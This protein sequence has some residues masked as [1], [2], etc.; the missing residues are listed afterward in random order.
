MNEMTPA[1]RTRFDDYLQRLRLELRGTGPEVAAEVEQSVREHIE[2]AL[3]EAQ[4]PVSE[5]DII[6]ILDRLGRPEQWVG[7]EERP[8]PRAAPDGAHARTDD[9][10]LPYVAFGLVLVAVA[11]FI[12]FGFMLL[13]PAM[14]VSR[15]WIEQKRERGEPLGARRWLVYPAIALVLAFATALL[16]FFVPLTAAS[17]LLDTETR[18]FFDIPTHPAGELRF[19]AGMRS[20]VFGSWWLIAAALCA[21]FVR[22]IRFVFSPLLDGLRRKHFAVLAAIGAL[23]ASAGAALIYYRH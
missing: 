1:A 3:D 10:R 15:A 16:L 8:T 6:G 21:G 17:S 20:V 12:F 2:I 9:S 11:T 13:I 23:V 14:F 18:Q 7:D 4:T 19:V 22:P 5:T